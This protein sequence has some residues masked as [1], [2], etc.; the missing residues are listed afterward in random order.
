M[1][2]ISLKNNYK[3]SVDV[4]REDINAAFEATLKFEGAASPTGLFNV[5]DILNN[6][7]EDN[8]SV[9]KVYSDSAYTKLLT[10]YSTYKYLNAFSKIITAES[11]VA[12]TMIIGTRKIV[13]LSTVVSG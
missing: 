10:T 11:G 12:C 13:D 9:I 2:Y 8:L 4:L 7:T 6:F 3:F 5:V 1:L